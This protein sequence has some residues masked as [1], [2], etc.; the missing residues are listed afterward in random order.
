MF[1]ALL[2]M[3]A[4]TTACASLPNHARS[5]DWL[6]VVA[7]AEDDSMLRA[8]IDTATTEGGWCAS[9]FIDHATQTIAISYVEPAHAIHA[10]KYKTQFRCPVGAIPVHRH[11]DT[12]HGPSQ[13][14]FI[15]LRRMLIPPPA[16]IVMY[17]H[18]HARVQYIAY[19]VR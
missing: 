15:E 9:G 5:N 13:D 16:A 19:A 6:V 1:R 3:L 7:N 2:T 11:L 17:G 10:E 18:G 14:D 4:L 8:G 12:H